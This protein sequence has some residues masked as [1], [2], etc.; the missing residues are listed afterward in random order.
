MNVHNVHADEMIFSES[1]IFFSSFKKDF[2]H[3]DHQKM[4]SE[5]H[6]QGNVKPT[7]LDNC[8]MPKGSPVKVLATRTPTI[9]NIWQEMQP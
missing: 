4:K 7:A 3:V 1:C 8:G 9:L 2:S 6:G 5:K